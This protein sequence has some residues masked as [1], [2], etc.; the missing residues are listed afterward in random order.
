MKKVLVIG[1]GGSGKS[2]LA[3]Q[4][5]TVLGL[6]VLH[7]DSFYWKAGW[8]EPPKDQW[9]DTVEELIDREAWI[10]DG[11]YSG[12]LAQRIEA[13]DTIVFLDLS[14]ILCL[15]RIVKRR[16]TYRHGNRPDI[17]EGCN[18]QLNLEFVAWVFNYSHRSKPKVVKLIQENSSRKK[19][20]WLRSRREVDSFLKNP[21][22][23]KCLTQTS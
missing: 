22:D 13:C 8:V 11:N 21:R 10:V 1:S 20:V 3:R 17:A 23:Y 14:R 5:G 19:I 4:L 7:L 15:C 16:L 6:E 18:E 9:R 12:T 2:T